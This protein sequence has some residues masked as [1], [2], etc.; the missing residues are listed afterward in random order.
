MVKE[1]KTQILENYNFDGDIGNFELIEEWEFD[2]MNED[3]IDIKFISRTKIK[4]DKDK[5]IEL[6]AR[7][8]GLENK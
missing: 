8:L 7:I 2:D 4:S 5:I 3:L 6:E 1:I